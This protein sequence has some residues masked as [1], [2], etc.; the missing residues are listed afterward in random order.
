M[1]DQTIGNKTEMQTPA[2]EK[3]DDM[4]WGT[5]TYKHRRMIFLPLAATTD[6]FQCQE[7]DEETK[8]TYETTTWLFDKINKTKSEE[9]V[10]YSFRDISFKIGKW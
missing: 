9:I 7:V 4:E 8:E 10:T 5:S 2:K 1:E 6:I 3:E